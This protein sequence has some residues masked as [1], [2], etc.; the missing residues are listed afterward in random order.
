[1]AGNSI[2]A[3]M[4]KLIE[5]KVK[6][7][8][9]PLV[10]AAFTASIIIFLLCPF[11]LLQFICLGLF[12]VIL[13][14]FF[15]ALVLKSNI[16][17]ERNTKALKLACKEKSEITFTIKNFSPLTAHVCYYFDSVPYFYIFD[18]GNKGVTALRPH[19]IKKI[20]YKVT[21]QERGLFHA[22][23]VRIRT[24]D[25][26]GLFMIDT[27][28]PCPLE[29]TVRPARIKLIT[30]VIPGFPQGNLKINNP[31]YEDITMRRSI[32]EY[33]NGDEQKRIN[34]RASA[35]FDS[36]YTNQYEASFDA[37]FFVFLNLAKEDYDLHNRG[38]YTEKAIE[39]AASIVEK[40]R[41]MRQQCGFA[42]YGTGFP[43]LPPGQNQADYILDLLSLIKCEDGKLS[44]SPSKKFLPQLPAGC[45]FFEI[46]PEEVEKYFLKVESNQEN[47][48]TSNVGIMKKIN[49]GSKLEHKAVSEEDIEKL[50]VKNTEGAFHE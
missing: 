3:F 43:Y 26:L 27:E 9:S 6:I 21:S 42:A 10:L 28:I 24:S 11:K 44:Y 4:Q 23:P 40:S 36:L 8:F 37:P 22:G 1:M 5:E 13:F 29:I 2:P 7:N 25:P 20:T 17:I 48:N 15:W 49:L 46:G 14:S 32:R 38:Y 47:I 12:S 39:I 50:S 45:L 18:E 19:E 30:E 41:V 34:W 35:K 31:C 16:K 33:M